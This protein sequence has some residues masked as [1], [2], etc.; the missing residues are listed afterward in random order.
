LNDPASG[1][2]AQRVADFDKQ[3]FL[4]GAVRRFDGGFF[5]TAAA[6]IRFIALTSR[7]SPA[8]RRD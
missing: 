5:L 8:S 2:R 1:P 3:G 4:L 6:L 7:N